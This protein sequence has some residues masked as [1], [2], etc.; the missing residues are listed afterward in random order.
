[1]K[2]S[3]YIGFM[4]RNLLIFCVVAMVP[5][6]SLAGTQQKQAFSRLVEKADAI[7]VG[8]CEKVESHWRKNKIYTSATVNVT[9]S[10][11]GNAPS[12][13]QVEY[14]GG[15]AI[16]P[17]LNA[18]VSM[19][20]SN[21]VSFVEGEH[22]VLFLKKDANGNYRMM[23]KNQGKIGIDTEEGTSRRYIHSRIKKIHADQSG[24]GTAIVS[25]EKMEL[26]DFLAYIRSILLQTKK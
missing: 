7:V 16:H 4:S 13:I 20:V 25:A 14:L 24:N 2:L 12:V 17:K 8:K 9:E 23:G 5:V 21:G 18:P 22:S 1:M 11:E 15:T 3:E 10:I 6:V 26:H 19:K